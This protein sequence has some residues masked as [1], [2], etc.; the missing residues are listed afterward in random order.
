MTSVTETYTKRS[1]DSRGV[2]YLRAEEAWLVAAAHPGVVEVVRSHEVEDG[3]WELELR[4]VAGGDL[5]Q[6]PGWSAEEVAGFGAAA[7]TTLADLHDLGIVHQRLGPEHLLVDG[8]G[9]PLL[10]GFGGAR[11]WD[12]GDQ[13]PDPRP[14]DVA[15]LAD[16]LAQL[17]PA[18]APRD[19]R[20]EL[21]RATPRG[22]RRPPSARQLARGLTA[23]V[24]AARLPVLG[25]SSAGSDGA[26]AGANRP[27]TTS[28]HLPATVGG[29]FAGPEAARGAALTAAGP[30]GAAGSAESVVPIGSLAKSEPETVAGPS[31]VRGRR[32][33]PHRSLRR[34]R[35]IEAVAAVLVVVG[36][37]VGLLAVSHR[38]N[39]KGGSSRPA[40]S[41]PTVDRGCGPVARPGG[42]LTTVSGR[43]RFG[44]P[45]DAVVLGRWTCTAQAFP[46]ILRPSTGQLWVFDAW[47]RPGAQVASRLVAVV[48]DGRSLRV[49]PDRPGC[50]GLAV[51]TGRGRVVVVDPRTR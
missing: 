51:L 2:A 27:A 11:R 7:A 30:P 24:P 33:R 23:A 14:A 3:Q 47:A 36:L 22:R 29:S 16:C 37:G 1:G 15:A 38:S 28:G 6:A 18:D 10:C 39:G 19:L 26:P 20:R 35:L 44:S 8:A 34:P 13:G 43:Y 12:D 31:P 46:A 41:C 5:T 40:A 50:D 21:A 48:S 9:R 32:S 42:V 45:A 4:L 25:G 49:V 17:L